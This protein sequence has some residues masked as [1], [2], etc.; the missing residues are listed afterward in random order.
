MNYRRKMNLYVETLKVTA[1]SMFSSSECSPELDT[2]P[3]LDQSLI[4]SYKHL[5]E[6]YNSE[7]VVYHRQYLLSQISKQ[8]SVLFSW[9]YYKSYILLNEICNLL[10]LNQLEIAYWSL[11]LEYNAHRYFIP[12]LSAYFTGY[13]AKT[14]MNKVIGPYEQRMSMR[15]SNFKLIYYNW[16][17]ICDCAPEFTVKE[18]SVRYANLVKKCSGTNKDYQEIIDHLIEVPQKKSLTAV[19]ENEPPNQIEGLRQE[20]KD[21]QYQLMQ[22]DILSPLSDL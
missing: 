19:E 17:L 5:E 8:F 10:H 18:I 13:Q 16:L 2:S 11:V 14:C 9:D 12:V 22:G 4:K 1:D 20:L 15:I 21:F 3:I 6:T 7:G